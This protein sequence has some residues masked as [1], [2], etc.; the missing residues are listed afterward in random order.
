[1]SHVNAHQK[2]VTVVFGKEGNI[3]NMGESTARVLQITDADN[4][5][6][7]GLSGISRN[8]CGISVLREGRT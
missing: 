2:K 3:S 8:V 6:G 5:E 7:V 1:M 4:F